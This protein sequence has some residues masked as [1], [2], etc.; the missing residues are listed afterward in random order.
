MAFAVR[1]MTGVVWYCCC[2]SLLVPARA[3]DPST[4]LIAVHEEALEAALGLEPGGWEQL[5]VASSRGDTAASIA[6]LAAAC[7]RT[8]ADLS[9]WADLFAAY[10]L[11]AD[12]E[13]DTTADATASEDLKFDEVA[14]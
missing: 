9:P 5:L 10:G 1:W 2:I 12:E 6:T 14:W 13:S 3:S 8:G 11:L 4:G 7:A